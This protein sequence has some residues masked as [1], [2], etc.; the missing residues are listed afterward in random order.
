MDADGIYHVSFNLINS[1]DDQ[2]SPQVSVQAQV[3]D[4]GGNAIGSIASAAMIKPGTTVF[5][6]ADGANPLEVVVPTF[7]IKTIQQGT[8]VSSRNNT[9]TVTL[10]ANYD[11]PD[12]STVTISGLTGSITDDSASLNIT[13]T[14]NRL[15]TTAA[16]TKSTGTLL[17]TAE[18]GGPVGQTAYTVTFV[19]TN[20]AQSQESPGVSVMA[21]ISGNLGTLVEKAMVKTGQPLYGVSAG[22]DP[23][24]VLVPEITVKS[25][26]QLTPVAGTTNTL[27][28]TLNVNYDLATGSKVTISGLTGSQTSQTASLSIAVTAGSLSSSVLG[29]TGGFDSQNLVLTAASPNSPSSGI[30]YTVAFNLVNGASSQGSPTIQIS[31]SIVD[32][33]SAPLLD[34]SATNMTKNSAGTREGVAGGA[35][36]LYIIEPAFTVKSIRQFQPLTN[37]ENTIKVT[38]TTN[39]NF[40]AGSVIELTDLKVIQ[41]AAGCLTLSGPSSDSFKQCAQWD[42]SEGTLQ[43]TVESVISSGSPYSF[44]FVL[45]NADAEQ[46]ARDVQIRGSVKTLVSGGTDAP[47]AAASMTQSSDAAFGIP[48][49]SAVLKIVR[50]VFTSYAIAQ[51]SLIPGSSNTLSLT[52]AINCDLIEGSQISLS[53]LTGAETSSG[54]LAI[55][56]ESPN[57][58]LLSTSSDWSRD[59][60]DGVLTLFVVDRVSAGTA[61]VVQVNLVNG[62]ANQQPGPAV[63]VQGFAV[64]EANANV[65]PKQSNISARTMVHPGTELHSIVNGTAAMTIVRSEFVIHN[66]SHSSP[67]VDTNNTFDCFFSTVID[68]EPGAH[69]IISGLTATAQPSGG[70]VI[71]SRTNAAVSTAA[72]WTNT[73]GSLV[74]FVTNAGGGMKANGVLNSHAGQVH[75]LS[76][77]LTNPSTGQFPPNITI[78]L[79]Q[80]NG[81]QDIPPTPMTTD[82]RGGLFSALA[83]ADMSKRRVSR[84]NTRG[85]HPS[86]DTIRSTTIVIELT[87]TARLHA[88]GSITVTGLT[89]AHGPAD[90]QLNLISGSS[91]E[92]SISTWSLAEGRLIFAL[93]NDIMAGV[94]RGSQNPYIIKFILQ[95]PTT[96][97]DSPSPITLEVSDAYYGPVINRTMERG[98]E[99]EAP[100]LVNDFRTLSIAQSDPS[101]D[102]D[103]VLTVTL[104]MRAGLEVAKEHFNVYI[105]G[106]QGST[107]ESTATLPLTDTSHSLFGNS[108]KWVAGEWKP[109]DAAV[110]GSACLVLT[111][112]EK[113][114]PGQDYKFSF[115]LHNKLTPQPAPTVSIMLYASDKST[116]SWEKVLKEQLPSDLSRNNGNNA[117]MLIAGFLHARAFQTSATA[118][119]PNTI[120]IEVETQSS[121][122]VNSS[123]TFTSDADHLYYGTAE[124][125]PGGDAALFS[126]AQGHA[127]THVAWNRSLLL[128]LLNYTEGT[129]RYTL[130]LNVTNPGRQSPP[131]LTVR[132]NGTISNSNASTPVDS[133]VGSTKVLAVAGFHSGSAS[134]TNSIAG[135]LNT[136]TLVFQVTVPFLVG[137]VAP[138]S[139][140]FHSNLLPAC[141]PVCAHACMHACMH[142]YTHPRR[143]HLSN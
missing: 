67:V 122:M 66:V 135:Q 54:S 86:A 117:A 76:W 80:K 141:L 47:V 22:Y 31:A 37:I 1:V 41:T 109:N 49:G 98:E 39:C 92:L 5:G 118:R 71:S 95:N 20:P 36:A 112:E 143:H 68:I 33:F 44:I 103:N 142:A 134:Q 72:R 126:G 113:S 127:T 130:R 50:P 7:S 26:E 119:E 4:S 28:V 124:F 18:N 48:A 99:N 64:G 84:V 24:K 79:Q 125:L 74:V 46:D 111:V 10:K 34:I 128:Y 3:L 45:R 101:A 9:I 27:T 11:L 114:V 132:H 35:E 51:S 42:R 75:H 115:T 121:L 61:L 96:G 139:V 70:V 65:A 59:D 87:A 133:G 106:L 17:L 19:L 78:A 60:P 53:G 140:L 82:P 30:D 69:I 73:N 81:R 8:P 137:E 23:L 90:N 138:Y 91:S 93:S 77:K 52:L 29:S 21:E 136:L 57:A 2:P 56:V 13:S 107:T 123:I 120:H 55:N 12:T 108:A 102:T 83:V 100:L 62:Q 85:P 43:M 15:G 110:V 131:G 25:I 88:G 40:R 16:W 116:I 89:G 97:Q 129:R 63:S 14:D 105:C 94:T 104:S 58:A 6:V 32:T 38:I